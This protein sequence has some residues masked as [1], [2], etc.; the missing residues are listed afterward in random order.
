MMNGGRTEEEWE[1]LPISTIKL[2]TVDYFAQEE[3]LIDIHAAAIAKAF[4][5]KSPNGV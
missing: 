2:L 3:R 5:P 4:A 1:S